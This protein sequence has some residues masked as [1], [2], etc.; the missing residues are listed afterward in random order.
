MRHKS[1]RYLS[2]LSSPGFG[3]DSGNINNHA[4]FSFSLKASLYLCYLSHISSRL[5]AFSFGHWLLEFSMS[6]LLHQW[7]AS[8]LISPF[9]SLVVYQVCSKV[10]GCRSVNLT[11]GARSRRRCTCVMSVRVWYILPI[12]HLIGG[13]SYQRHSICLQI[14][15]LGT[16]RFT[17]KKYR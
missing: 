13:T 5:P 12:V 6:V 17:W 7:Q 9:H 4:A 11:G 3:Y 14:L 10:L 15:T 1:L 16:K 2:P 8:F